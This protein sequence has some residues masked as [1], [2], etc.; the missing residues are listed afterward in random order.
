M[1]YSK[2]NIDE[3]LTLKKNIISTLLKFENLMCFDFQFDATV[4]NLN[5]YMDAGHYSREIN[6]W[7]LHQI[8]SGKYQVTIDNCDEYL[9]NL[10]ELVLGYDYEKSYAELEAIIQ[11][12]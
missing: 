9:S 11:A 4:L 12:R 8:A 5:H 3:Y 6:D 10:R 7:I 2:D 1:K